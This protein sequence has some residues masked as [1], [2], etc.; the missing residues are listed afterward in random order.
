MK[1]KVKNQRNIG[2]VFIY[3]KKKYVVIEDV[4]YDGCPMCCFKFKYPNCMIGGHCSI[5]Q[6]FDH[7]PV[8]FK[9]IE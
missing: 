9:E 7:K 8:I 1:Q 6:R 5:S 3:N 2:D 4:S